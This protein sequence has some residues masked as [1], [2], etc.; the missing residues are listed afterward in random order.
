MM[1]L[2]PLDPN[3]ED[4]VAWMYEVRSHSQVVPFFFAPPPS[5]FQQHVQFLK[6]FIDSAEREFFIILMGGI[7]CGYCQIIHR[8]EEYEVGFA[9]HPDWWGM[10]IGEMSAK[11]LINHI[12]DNCGRKDIVLYVKAGNNRALSLYTKLGFSLE[13]QEEERCFMRKKI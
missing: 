8:G 7:K 9:L 13:K 1:Q 2:I 10:G 11:W 5:S 6:K 12:K 4:Q 3:K